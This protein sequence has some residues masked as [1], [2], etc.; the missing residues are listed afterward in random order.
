MAN[1]KRTKAQLQAALKEKSE[2]IEELKKTIRTKQT[3]APV[4][5]SPGDLTSDITEAVDKEVERKISALAE[6]GK[7]LFKIILTKVAGQM[8]DSTKQIQLPAPATVADGARVIIFGYPL[9]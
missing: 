7:P 5:V 4:A 8:V 1:D 2:T 3:A 9:D 6:R